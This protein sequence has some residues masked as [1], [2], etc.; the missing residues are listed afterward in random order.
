MKWVGV[1]RCNKPIS[2]GPTLAGLPGGV[3]GD[4]LRLYPV[5]S[6]DEYPMV[7]IRTPNLDEPVLVCRPLPKKVR[8][9]NRTIL[10]K[11]I[12]NVPFIASNEYRHMF[13]LL[14]LEYLR[15]GF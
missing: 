5:K 9:Y 12:S 10:A 3:A 7:G 11:K 6:N 14:E 4:L 15:A 1:E 8:I 13:F 2:G